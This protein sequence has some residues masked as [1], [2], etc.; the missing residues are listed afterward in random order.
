[1]FLAEKL[2]NFLKKKKINFFT[3]VPDSVLKNFSL[4]IKK[5][6]NHIIAVN[7][8][9]AVALGIGYYLATKK[10]PL[11]YMQNSGL[12]NAVNPLISIAHK[13]VYSIP[14]LLLIGWRGYPKMKDE[15]QHQAKGSITTKILKNLNIKYC[16]V[17]NNKDF[18]N[19]GKLITYGKKNKS[20]V[21]CLVL[22]GMM[23][24]KIKRKEYKEKILKLTRYEFI[25]CLLKNIKKSTKIISTT[26]FT[27]R[28]LHHI[29]NENSIKNGKDFYM[30]GGMGHASMV[31]LAHSLF[32][33]NKTICLDGD[34]SFLMHMGS[35]LTTGK[36]A[37]KN[38]KHILLNNN[39]HE[40][41]GG[42]KTY[43]ENLDLKKIVKS[44]R[45]K[46]YFSI[47][48]SN[49][50]NKKIKLFLSA[51]GP[52]F[53]EVEIKNHSIKGLGRPKNLINIKSKFIK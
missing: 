9:S 37:S 11:I 46:N 12:G 48:K 31:S 26:G 53:L 4:S 7:E 52:S 6:D 16:I 41:V 3:G 17:K 1:M 13:K 25:S 38:F 30:V 50:I 14:S 10:I 45:Y 21:A 5:S 49:E 19:L 32:Y 15:P 34:G 24:T 8:G 47:N 2:I 51:T 22:P 42:Q 35:L 18:N 36:F 40:S 20:P 33:K 27:S 29:R 28:E 39:S 23:G 44:F 43:T